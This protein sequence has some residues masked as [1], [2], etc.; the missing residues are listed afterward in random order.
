[1]MRAETFLEI[2]SCWVSYSSKWAHAY[3]TS[4]RCLYL[5]ML[6][7]TRNREIRGQSRMVVRMWWGC[8]MWYIFGYEWCITSEQW[9]VW[10]TWLR[11]NWKMTSK[12]LRVWIMKWRSN[13]H[14]FYAFDY[15][16]YDLLSYCTKEVISYLGTYDAQWNQLHNVVSSHWIYLTFCIERINFPRTSLARK[17]HSNC[18][19][20]LG[21]TMT[22][23]TW[24]ELNLEL[25]LFCFLRWRKCALCD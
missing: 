3:P 18:R 19:Q 11:I 12:L 14:I 6:N 5:S 16:M 4:Y 15:N 7:Y 21:M 2:Y 25:A 13:A 1:M 8:Q 23:E 22:Y 24:H 10:V 20:T 17:R 9:N